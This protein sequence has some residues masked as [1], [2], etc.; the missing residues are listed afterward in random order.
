MSVALDLSSLYSTPSE[1]S[2]Y[3]RSADEII[4]TS[5]EETSL[6][7]APTSSISTRSA[8]RSRTPTMRDRVTL[9]SMDDRIWIDGDHELIAILMDYVN[10]V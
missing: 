6:N 10:S 7:L 8:M 9:P 3:E 4:S 1:T 5:T 2:S